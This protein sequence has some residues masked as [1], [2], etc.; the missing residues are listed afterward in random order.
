MFALLTK[1]AGGKWALGCRRSIV[2]GIRVLTKLEVGVRV[3]PEAWVQVR[4]LTVLKR[5]PEGEDSQLGGRP[6]T[7]LRAG[8]IPEF[9][10]AAHQVAWPRLKRP[11]FEPTQ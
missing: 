7:E 9:G 6:G 4:P 3:L 8:L 5:R 11:G 2:E 10:N 1:G